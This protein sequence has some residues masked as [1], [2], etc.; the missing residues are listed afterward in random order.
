MKIVQVKSR[1]ILVEMDYAEIKHITKSE[2]W[3]KEHATK[4]C[5]TD[6]DIPIGIWAEE[7]RITSKS[8]LEET[9]RTFKAMQQFFEN[10]LDVINKF[11]M[12][13]IHD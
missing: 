11:D 13:S 5:D 6:K 12:E 8:K 9:I 3:C 2:I 7:F 1:S 4:Y 10:R